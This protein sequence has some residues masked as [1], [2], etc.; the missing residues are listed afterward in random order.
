MITKQTLHAFVSDTRTKIEP[1]WSDDLLWEKFKKKSDM[2]RSAGFCGPSSVYL[3]EE[4]TKTF[5]HESFSIAV[6]K[7]YVGA[8]EWIHGKH[9]W[10]VWHRSIS[11][12]VVLD[13]TADQ[14]GKVDDTVLV[15]DIETL[16]ASGIHYVAH[17]LARS[18]D[19]VD[20]SP[21]RRA[22]MLRSRVPN[23]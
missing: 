16:S 12:A 4:L 7:V 10:V 6:G 14:S 2:P 22:A 8:S 19:E 17:Q 9:V 18:I 21:R 1:H 20:E 15:E 23:N 3:R 5:P 11:S 13:I